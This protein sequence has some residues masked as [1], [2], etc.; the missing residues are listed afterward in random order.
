M[1]N[2]VLGYGQGTPGS[3]TIL[4]FRGDDCNALSDSM[5]ISPINF[6]TYM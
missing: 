6:W 3:A 2:E 4:G 1:A 5:Q